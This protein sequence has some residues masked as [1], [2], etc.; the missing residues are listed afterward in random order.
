MTAYAYYSSPLG[1]LEVV[2]T[3][4][5]ISEINFVDNP[6]S[7]T[8]DDPPPALRD[9]LTQLDEYFAGRRRRFEVP[10]D[11]SRGTDFH[12]EVWRLVQAIPYGRTRS[13]STIAETLGR[14]HASRAVG[15]A[16]GRNPIPIIIPCHRVIGKD[17]GLT[18]YAY[19]LEMKEALL[20]I[21]N[22]KKFAHQAE[23][24]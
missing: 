7:E 14:P 10:L 21:E 16:N 11:L 13:Y 3:E 20:A 5:G 6:R 24:W 23:L 18:G 17:G 22:P 4:I 2:C 9:C 15:Q 8:S 12:R 1:F 19:G